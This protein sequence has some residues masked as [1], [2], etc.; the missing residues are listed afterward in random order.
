MQ[1]PD[2]TKKVLTTKQRNKR[3]V[4]ENFLVVLVFGAALITVCL[5]VYF[6]NKAN[7]VD[8]TLEWY[9]QREI[10]WELETTY[11]E[12]FALETREVKDIRDD[13]YD[14]GANHIVYETSVYWFDETSSIGEMHC[15]KYITFVYYRKVN[16]NFGE[17]A[18]YDILDCD[19]CPLVS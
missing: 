3:N 2:L 19:C 14:S 15:D 9:V 6:E 11:S 18:H 17:Y 8:N 7:T 16:G 12:E 13:V 1:I 10:M 4:L 5:L